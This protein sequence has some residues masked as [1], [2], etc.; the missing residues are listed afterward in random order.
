MVVVDKLR[1]TTHFIPIKSTIKV[2]DV[3]D[4]FMKDIFRLHGL[5]KTII[6]DR[7]AKFTSKFWKDLFVG[8]EHN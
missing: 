5:S 7:D 2:I 6:S 3:V 1:K 4:I 8:W